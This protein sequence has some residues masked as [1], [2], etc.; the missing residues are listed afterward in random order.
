MSIS[1]DSEL[2]LDEVDQHLEFRKTHQQEFQTAW[3][4]K[5]VQARLALNEAIS[6]GGSQDPRGAV[7][8]GIACTL[9]DML[10]AQSEGFEYLPRA[11]KGTSDPPVIH[12]LH[13]DMKS[14]HQKLDSLMNQDRKKVPDVR[15]ARRYR[16]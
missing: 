7:L 4:N 3:M 9:N 5:L 12:Q 6:L 8:H 1:G 10:H 11:K 14:I 2:E 16:I 15:I 13:E